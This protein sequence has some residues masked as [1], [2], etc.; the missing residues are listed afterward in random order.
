MILSN[1]EKQFLSQSVTRRL[2]ILFWAFLKKIIT[3]FYK[4]KKFTNFKLIITKC[5]K[6]FLQILTGIAKCDKNVLQSVT[7]ITK[8]SKYYKE[9]RN[10]FRGCY[11]TRF[12]VV[13]FEKI[14]QWFIWKLNFLLN[15]LSNR[16]KKKL[17][18]ELPVKWSV[19]NWWS[20]MIDA[21]DVIV[22]IVQG[23]YWI[24]IG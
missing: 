17:L 14:F 13:R 9:R 5:D 21:R 1:F 10:T 23:Y 8:C 15:G 22:V 4:Q 18:N 7:G 6:N 2:H 12:I 19:T 3:K 24:I 20:L 16:S 11:N